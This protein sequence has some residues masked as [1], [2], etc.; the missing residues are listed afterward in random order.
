MAPSKIAQNTWTTQGGDF[1]LRLLS[2][3]G[4]VLGWIDANG[5][6]GGNLVPSAAAVQAKIVSYTVQQADIDNGIALITV[7]WTNPFVDTNYVANG[8]VQHIS[9]PGEP[10]NYFTDVMISK[11]VSQT[12]FSINVDTGVGPGDV[13][14]FNAM[15]VP[16]N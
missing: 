1:F 12:V 5:S 10:S 9:G 15:A 3:T 6:L 11:S 2:K 13:V 16:T 7:V 14:Q 4:T 8:I